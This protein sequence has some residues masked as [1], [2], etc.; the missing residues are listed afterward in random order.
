MKLA[1]LAPWVYN[2]LFNTVPLRRFL[3]KLV[4]FHPD[5]TIPLLHKTTLRKWYDK[6]RE[7]EKDIPKNQLVY[8]FCDEFTNY[9]DVAIGIKTILLLESL[10]YS[11]VIPTHTESGRTYLSKGMVKKAREIAIKNVNE[12]KDLVN[13]ESPI[14]GIE[15]SAILTLR[16][17][18]TELVTR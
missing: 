12:L 2:F 9:N 11:V 18:Y 3:N 5:S 15:P 13:D 14:I 4:G 8:L 7:H 16:D 1:M 17:E 10:G 6:H